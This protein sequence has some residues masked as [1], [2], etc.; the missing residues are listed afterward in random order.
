[1]PKL[2]VGFV[3]ENVFTNVV[4]NTTLKSISIVEATPL[5][6]DDFGVFPVY[7]RTKTP[8][9]PPPPPPPPAMPP[10]STCNVGVVGL[11]A[12]GQ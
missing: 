9:P 12:A 2:P 11:D 7:K 10:C 5:I 1:M 4:V 8:P 6:G 3:W